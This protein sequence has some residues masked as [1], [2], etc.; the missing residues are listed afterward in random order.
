MSGTASDT[1]NKSLHSNMFR[2]IQPAKPKEPEEEEP[3][4]SNMFRLIPRFNY[5]SII[6][7]KNA[8]ILSTPMNRLFKIILQ[9][10][11]PSFL[12]K[13]FSLL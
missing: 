12:D 1:L 6:Q 13:Q 5:E 10:Q 4:H 3:L 2:L 8:C 11:F 9:L 7:V